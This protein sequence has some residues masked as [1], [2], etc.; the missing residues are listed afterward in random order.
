MGQLNP[1][2]LFDGNCRE[3]MKFY[4]GCFGGE[5]SLMTVGES[6]MAK[7]MPPDKHKQIMHARLNS[8]GV[9]IM[10]ADGMGP[11][12]TTPGGNISLSFSGANQKEIDTVFSKLSAGGKVLHAPKD[13][14][15]GYYGDLSDRY[16]INWMLVYEKPRP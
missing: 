7:D 16:G 11:G 10:A 15:F 14:F 13:E 2:L 4:Q 6:P 1:Y 5:L 3:A 9:L 8:G 12:G